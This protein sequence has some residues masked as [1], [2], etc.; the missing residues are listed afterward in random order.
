[1]LKWYR[2]VVI[3]GCGDVAYADVALQFLHTFG[4][5]GWVLDQPSP[6]AARAAQ[7]AQSEVISPT[8]CVGEA[9]VGMVALTF[10]YFISLRASCVCF[11]FWGYL[12]SV[13]KYYQR[14]HAQVR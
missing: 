10:F 13:L 11:I 6:L 1:M 8:L 2:F 12:A 7:A 3:E 5:A 9:R 14:Q 4:W